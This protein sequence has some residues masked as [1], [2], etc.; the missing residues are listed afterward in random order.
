MKKIIGCLLGLGFLSMAIAQEKQYSFADLEAM[1][2]Q[3]QS[4]VYQ[5]YADTALHI[6]YR[7]PADNTG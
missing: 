6:Y 7:K 4:M 5:K 3:I 2:G 1:N